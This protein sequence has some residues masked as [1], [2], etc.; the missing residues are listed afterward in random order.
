MNLAFISIF[1]TLLLTSV[2]A[3]KTSVYA[4]KSVHIVRSLR[5]GKSKSKHSDDDS[6]L[7]KV[8]PEPPL[9]GVLPGVD[10]P[11][12]ILA[13]DV[14]YPPYAQLGP[15]EE[16]SPV[17]GFGA[18]VAKGLMDVCD[19]DVFTVQT[20]WSRCWQDEKIGEGLALG[21]FHACA[22]YTHA[23]GVRNRYIEFS[24]PILKDNKAAGILTRL[25]SS[26]KPLVDGNSDLN[27]MKVV[28]V[29]G[30]APTADNLAIVTNDCV[31]TP[32]KGYEIVAPSYTSDVPNDDAL[33][34]LLDGDADAMW[35]CK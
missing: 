14:D 20:Q 7:I 16:D 24:S 33:R 8:G 32:F 31:G 19:I 34:T 23:A 30:F 4:E 18:D 13:Q 5:K 10:R 9:A 1:A 6:L 17:S 22:T 11:K 15:V 25:D 12:L 26:G 28:D 29:I 35:V 3:E 21:E 2:Y 27:G